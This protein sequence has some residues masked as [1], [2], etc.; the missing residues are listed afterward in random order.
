MRR[1]RHVI[2]FNFPQSIPCKD[3]S[4]RRPRRSPDRH[5]TNTACLS[6]PQEVEDGFH[7]D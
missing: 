2:T 3:V 7:L 4:G 1:V 6:E 5:L